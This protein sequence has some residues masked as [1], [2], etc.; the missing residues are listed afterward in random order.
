MEEG[1]LNDRDA[2]A[3][4]DRQ[5]RY[6]RQSGDLPKTYSGITDAHRRADLPKPEYADGEGF[7]DW[8]RRNLGY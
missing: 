5:S 6:Q 2:F 4:V 7:F 1:I 8:L 3:L